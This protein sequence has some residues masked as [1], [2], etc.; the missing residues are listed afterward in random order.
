LVLP[1]APRVYFSH[2]TAMATLAPSILG[3]DFTRLGEE[4]ASAEAA[5][6][7][8]YHLDIMDGHF[9]PNI[10][11]GPAIVKTIDGLSDGFMD[12]HLM[13]SE[14]EKHFEAFARAGADSITFHWQVHPEPTPYVRQIRDL[15]LKAGLSINPDIP[16]EKAL[17]YLEQ[18]DLF[19]IMSVFPGFGGQSFIEDSIDRL[20]QARSFIDDE[21]LP[22][23]I[24]VD[25]GVDTDNGSTRTGKTS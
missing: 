6:I 15:G 19:L 21:G 3:A 7:D 11:F 9:V 14:P 13:L 8:F 1:I 22:C 20:S 18:F 12:V 16:V 25:G 4:I 2:F 23:K 17:P 24:Q 5:G 10:S